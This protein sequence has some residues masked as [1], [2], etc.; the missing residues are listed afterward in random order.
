MN[1]IPVSKELEDELAI[2][3][4]FEFDTKIPGQKIYLSF[5]GSK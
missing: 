3:A 4:I 2:F 5:T 1:Q